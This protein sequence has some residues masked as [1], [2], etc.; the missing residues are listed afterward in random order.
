V[1]I[2]VYLLLILWFADQLMVSRSI[3]GILGTSIGILVET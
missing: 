1:E 2:G 3:S